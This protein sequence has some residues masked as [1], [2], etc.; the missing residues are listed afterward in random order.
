MTILQEPS[1]P[2]AKSKTSVLNYVHNQSLQY[3]NLTLSIYSS[4]S[5][6]QQQHII[7]NSTSYSTITNTKLLQHTL[8]ILCMTIHKGY[9]LFNR[10]PTTILRSTTQ[11]VINI[12]N[13]WQHMH[14]R[15]I[16]TQQLHHPLTYAPNWSLI[17][18]LSLHHCRF[19]SHCVT[20]SIA[21]TDI[22]SM[23][24]DANNTKH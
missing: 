17:Y 12:S 6:T 2:S 1:Q 16:D 8:I 11:F 23:M 22:L 15:H 20:H 18:T 5:I 24:K 9:K 19:Y 21:H 13:N 10:T 7:T 4:N 14:V 3:N